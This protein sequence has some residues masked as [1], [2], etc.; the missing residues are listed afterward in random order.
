MGCQMP[1]CQQADGISRK[2]VLCR[3]A[4]PVSPQ[5]TEK[6]W[7]RRGG[8]GLDCFRFIFLG[9]LIKAW[10]GNSWNIKRDFGKLPKDPSCELRPWAWPG[11]R[12]FWVTAPSGSAPKPGV[13]RHF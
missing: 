8:W 6:S 5:A 7:G 3:Q 11:R 10:E 2:Q 1:E 13:K 9:V 4:P 12:R